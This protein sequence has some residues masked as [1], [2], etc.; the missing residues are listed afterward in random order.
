MERIA[1]PSATNPWLVKM[2]PGIYDLGDEALVMRPF[3]DI[4]GSGQGVT[5]ITSAGVF[6]VIAASDA[7]IRELTVEST[8]PHP[9]G[10]GCPTPLQDCYA[11]LVDTGVDAKITNATIH[12][13]S[14]TFP[15]GVNPGST[16]EV[17]GGSITCASFCHGVQVDGGSATLKGTSITAFGFLSR[18]VDAGGTVNL[19]NV[20]VDVGN[21]GTK[22]LQ[23][24]GGT[25]NVHNS[26][27]R[28]EHIL[29][30]GGQI[31]IGASQV[32][33]FGSA[34]GATCVASYDSSF[35]PLGANCL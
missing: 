23:A 15:L 26:I 24:L 32:E 3:V 18:G 7:E 17:N 22:A 16:V 20:T 14:G 9:P 25:I 29:V 5:S 4:E 2:E 27:I 35:T 11:V 12:T 8:S 1:T 10:L 21:G 34:T 28:G 33:L 13:T 6:A 19:I 31:N 30:A